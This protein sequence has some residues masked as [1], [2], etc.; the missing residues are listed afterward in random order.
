LAENNVMDYSLLVGIYYDS[1]ENKTDTEAA[2]AAAEFRCLDDSK[3][4]YCL[5]D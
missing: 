4:R 1:P 3:Q 5:N 2:A